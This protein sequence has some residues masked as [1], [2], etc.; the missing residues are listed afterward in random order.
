MEKKYMIGKLW[1]KDLTSPY[2]A[3]QW[4]TTPVTIKRKKDDAVLYQNDGVEHPRAWSSNAIE[5]CAAKYFR[6]NDIPEI[7]GEHSVRQLIKRVTACFRKHAV[8]RGYF[9]EAQGKVFEDELIAGFLTQKIGWNS[10]VWFNYGLYSEY[11][12][13]GGM[14]RDR[15]HVDPESGEIVRAAC[16][17]ERPSGAACFISSVED[18]LFTSDG[19]GMADLLVNEQKIFLTGA[20]DGLN[21]SRIRGHNEPIA[22]GGRSAGLIAYLKVRDA[23]AGYI[24]SGGKSRRSATLLCCDLDHP[25]IVDFIEWKDKEERKAT[26]LIAAGHEGGMEGDAYMTVSGQNSNNS[27]RISDA[28]LEAVKQDLDWHLISRVP[29]EKFPEMNSIDLGPRTP[30]SQGLLIM[31]T[32]ANP[33]AMI[34][35]NETTMHKIMSTIKAR[36][37]WD[38]ICS[39]AWR[40]GCPGVQFDDIMNAWNTTPHYGRINATNPCSE[41][42]L[43]DWSACNLGSVNLMPFFHDLKNPDWK[44]FEHA[45]KLMATSLDLVVDISTYP[46]EKHARGAWNLRPI[47]LNHGNIGAVLMRNGIPYDS[48]EGRSW[49]AAITSAMTLFAAQQSMALAK[50]MGKYPEFQYEAHQKVLAMHANGIEKTALKS[51]ERKHSGPDMQWLVDQWRELVDSSN[52]KK[53]GMRNASLTTMAPQGTIGLVLDQD[54]LGCEPDYC[55]VKYKKLIGGS[56]MVIPNQSV[57][58]ALLKLGYSESVISQITSYIR[59]FSTAEGCPAIKREDAAVFDCAAKPH[60][61]I[62]FTDLNIS[63]EDM[64]SATNAIKPAKTK[65]EALAALPKKLR[66]QLEHRIKIFVRSISIDGH[67]KALGAL[68]PNISMSCSKTVNMPGEATIED[69]ANAFKQAHKAGIKC[70][71]IYRDECRE[72]QPLNVSQ[73]TALQAAAKQVKKRGEGEW[74]PSDW[75]AVHRK[76][77]N[78]TANCDRF[79]FSIGD[80]AEGNQSV[81]VNVVLYPDSNQIM[82]LFVNLGKQGDTVNGMAHALARILSTS[83]QFGIPPEILGEKLAGMNFRP[84]GFLGKSSMFGIHKAASIPDLI[85]RL[86]MALPEYYA[87]DRDESIMY[88]EPYKEIKM[89]PRGTDDDDQKATAITESNARSF[90]FSGV[91]CQNC[92]SWKT[93]GSAKCQVCQDCGG[94]NGP[95]LG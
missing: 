85:G 28:F 59:R 10:P 29:A 78:H 8:S 9:D 88:P 40:T 1:T 93:V 53:H 66:D 22:G 76:T 92:G 17:Y 57:V 32:S 86:L 43:P 20:G 79:K 69:V 34:R 7:G 25:D 50:H 3:V 12:I 27:I 15:Y 54:T 81:F 46:T 75:P 77:P 44:G 91:Q 14:E 42:C 74:S 55:L 30:C 37:L 45:C 39:S 95:C 11:G 80:S 31:D 94:D 16:E 35:K 23:N 5:T 24:R 49:I 73:G 2:E 18:S 26:D 48:E 63:S 72:S 87:K 71:A 64:V 58:P 56:N 4:A 36:K 38:M 51:K 33:V 62:D 84:T 19:V 6:R 68:Q 70:L 47:G 83:M 65:E 90:G 13:K 60:N 52:L 41:V 21:I 82:E 67:I 89:I 61:A